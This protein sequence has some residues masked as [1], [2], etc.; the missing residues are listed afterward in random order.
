MVSGC[1]LILKRPREER[2]P[3]TLQRIRIG[4][5]G[6]ARSFVLAKA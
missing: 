5:V 1:S 6:H 2:V 4:L 3:W